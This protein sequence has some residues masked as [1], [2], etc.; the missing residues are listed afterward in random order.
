MTTPGHHHHA[1]HVEEPPP[2]IDA[3]HRHAPGEGAPQQEHGARANTTLA[4]VVLAVISLSTLGAGIGVGLLT[5]S[6]LDTL[7]SQEERA[8]L[9]RAAQQSRAYRDAARAE[10]AA[11]GWRDPTGTERVS[12]EKA[13]Q[14][15]VDRYGENT[16]RGS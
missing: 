2:H 7:K 12:I 15:V 9:V 6:R 16:S 3:W 14:V 8:A 10:Q 13:K 5:V 1:D 11:D 4:L